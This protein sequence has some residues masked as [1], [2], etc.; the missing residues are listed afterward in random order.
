VAWSRQSADA[1]KTNCQ[2][3]SRLAAGASS[4]LRTTGSRFGRWG[5]NDAGDPAGIDL[6][7]LQIQ[8]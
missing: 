5:A 2:Q 3:N 1:G 4:G 6:Q 8:E 7:D